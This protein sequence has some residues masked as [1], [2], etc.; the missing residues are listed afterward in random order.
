MR[1]KLKTE[2]EEFLTISGWITKHRKLGEKNDAAEFLN[3]FIMKIIEDL[4]MVRFTVT[5]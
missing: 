1:K 4:N 2:F 3:F 5:L